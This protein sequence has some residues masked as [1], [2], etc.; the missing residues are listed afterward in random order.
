MKFYLAGKMTGIPK[1]NYP[2]FDLVAETLRS[3]GYD[4]TS[5]AEMDSDETRAAAL[6]SR[7]GKFTKRFAT[8]E[9]WGD[10]LA[11]DVKLIADNMDAIILLPEWETSRGARLEAFVAI[12][13][14]YPTFLW[15]GSDIEP[16]KLTINIEGLT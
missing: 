7:T 8:G 10:F 14:G 6:R 15:T 2:L 4:I 5:P 1:F 16:I 9:T 12:S 11:R 3:R 13:C